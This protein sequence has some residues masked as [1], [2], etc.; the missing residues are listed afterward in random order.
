MEIRTLALKRRRCPLYTADC[1]YHTADCPFY[2]CFKASPARNPQECQRNPQECHRNP[3]H[4]RKPQDVSGLSKVEIG[5]GSKEKYLR[6]GPFSTGQCRAVPG[7]TGG[8]RGIPSEGRV[9]YTVRSL[10]YRAGYTGVCRGM[11][12]YAG[13]GGSRIPR[14][15]YYSGTHWDSM[16]SS[17]L[18]SLL[19]P[20]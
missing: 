10:C 15:I 11:P 12:G 18:G 9:P 19:L 4:R 16:A 7:S 13:R 20:G 17:C 5:Y 8:R 2:P 14:H 6:R 1:P 3:P